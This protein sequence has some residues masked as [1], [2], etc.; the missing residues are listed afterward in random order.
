MI[1]D[2]TKSRRRFLTGV[3]G[4]GAALGLGFGL[5]TLA[6]AARR[7]HAEP[8]ADRTDLDAG[9]WVEVED[10]PLEDLMREHAVLERVLLVYEEGARRLDAG[11]D[12]APEILA[13]AGGIVRRYIED[14]HERDEETHIFPRL[15]QIGAE[16][17][18]LKTL[19]EQHAAGRHLTSDVI[20]LATLATVRAAPERARLV[21][22]MRLF[23]RMYRPH[24][25]RENT[26][27]FPA[28]RKAVSEKEYEN[29]QRALEKSEHDAFGD[30]LYE[31]VL[32]EVR[33]LEGALGIGELA[34][35]T[36]P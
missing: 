33:G 35:F 9:V 28:F 22:A 18:L 31:T 32:D 26:V 34:G 13:K 25:A 19:R 4:A 16:L 36:P 11:A 27:L 10:T 29:L 17:D 7:G 12:F 15:E 2:E 3:G 21:G 8:S 14:H 6:K 5:G 23:I 20:G 1:R 24:A 30:H